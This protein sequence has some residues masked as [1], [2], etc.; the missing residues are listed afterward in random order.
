MGDTCVPANPQRVV[1]WG[2][3][4]LDP[5]L[6]LGVKPIAATPNVLGYVKEKLPAEQWQG[7]ED[8]SSPQGPNLERLLK[9][10][11]DLILGHA[12]G[13]EPIYLQLSQVAPTVLD[14][15]NDWKSKFRLFAEALGKTNDAQ[16]ILVN[17]EARINR[18]KAEM[19]NRLPMTAT[20][21]E[22]RPDVLIVYTKDTFPIQILSEAGLS[23]PSALEKYDWRSWALSQ[24]RLDEIAA[25]AIFISTWRGSQ[26]DNQAAQSA[27]E[28]LTS[29]PLWL[30]LSAV[31]Q[32][33]VY[34]VG[35]YIQGSG[36]LTANLILN[37]LFK[38][39][40]LLN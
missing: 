17:Y 33:R 31:K 18:F 5:V 24:E 6:A 19:G 11:P 38:Y 22:I 20:I 30:Q 9:L 27:L 28:K 16:Q 13:L 25:D 8:I 32:G 7:I 1:V 2:G 21:V 34:N 4:E 37:D 23:L 35:D 40:L 39:L 29:D 14:D 3:T 10:K 15:S 12:S 36:P 26:Q